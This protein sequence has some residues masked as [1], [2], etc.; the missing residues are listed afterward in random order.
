MHKETFKTR[1]PEKINTW[2]GT[3]EV[4]LV[5]SICC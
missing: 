2:L 5:I 4:Y 1:T 3:E